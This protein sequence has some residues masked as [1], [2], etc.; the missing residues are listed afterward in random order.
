LRSF[1]AEELDFLMEYERVMR[2]LVKKLDILQGDKNSYLGCLL[3]HI[4]HLEHQLKD[5]LNG[6]RG[7]LKYTR[8]IVQLMLTKLYAMDRFGPMLENIDYWMASCFH[9]AYKLT[10]IRMWNPMKL[11]EIRDRM[12]RMVADEMRAQ[13]PEKHRSH[14]ER[15]RKEAAAAATACM[16]VGDV[17]DSDEE[18][19]E[20]YCNLTNLF[21]SYQQEAALVE[22]PQKTFTELAKEFVQRWEST[23]A[24]TQLDDDAFMD[25]S[26]FKELFRR[27]NTGVAS[28]A[29]C[30]SFFSQGKDTLKPRQETMSSSNFEALMFLRGNAHLWAV[31]KP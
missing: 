20:R 19:A 1:T 25:S 9:P 11:T 24:T 21:N 12:I 27:T 30:E 2:P 13:D 4:I 18:K 14:P 26:V 28:S 6:L 5:L 22:E 16:S 31:P 3:P 7:S 29:A 8:E 23:P 17:D 15:R 10:W